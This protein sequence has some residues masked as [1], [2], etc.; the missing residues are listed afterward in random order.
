VGRGGVERVGNLL[1]PSQPVLA[2]DLSRRLEVLASLGQ[3]TGPQD[4]HV[5]AHD[6]LVVVDVGGAV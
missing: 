6:F 2:V 5:R 3:Q 1:L 4:D